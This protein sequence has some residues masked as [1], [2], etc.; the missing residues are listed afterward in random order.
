MKLRVVIMFYVI[1]NVIDTLLTLNGLDKTQEGG[2][3]VRAYMTHYGPVHGLI[4]AK[5]A[6]V[7]IVSL[8]FLIAELAKV[9]ETINLVYVATILTLLGGAMWLLV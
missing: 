7:S 2:P 3:I 6:L 8:V 1:A 5:I 4:V 9:K